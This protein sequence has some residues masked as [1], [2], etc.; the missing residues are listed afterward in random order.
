MMSQAVQQGR[1]HPF[2]LEHL[3]PF[4]EGQV[5][6][7]QQAAPFV[8]ISEHLEQQ[9]GTRSAERKIAEFVADQQVRLIQ[10]SQVTIEPVLFL[11]FFQAIDERG[12][13]EE[14]DAS[15]LPT[16]SQPQCGCGV[17][18]PCS[19]APNQADV[20]ITID[21]LTTC[22]LQDLLFGQRSRD[23]EVKRVEVLLDREGR[24]LD[25]RSQGVGPSRGQ[26][27]FR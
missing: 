26:F 19:G 11:R 3:V 25:P 27:Q 18:L 6:G 8:A 24:L 10:A 9:F 2:S 4:A 20:F 23:A 16:S 21:P 22:Q 5:A 15:P 12:R 7:D 17:R 14:P 1:C 13:S